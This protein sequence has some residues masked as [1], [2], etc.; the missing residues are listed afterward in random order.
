[1]TF[2]LFSERWLEEEP[3]APAAP[4][5]APLAV[6]D[7]DETLKNTL[8]V[9]GSLFVIVLILFCHLRRKYPRVYNVRNWVENLKTDLAQ[10]QYGYFNWIWKVFG[11]DDAEMMDQCGMDAICFVRVLE[12][13]FKLAAVGVVNS[14]WLMLIY[15]TAEDS[16]ETEH[17]F[18]ATVSL[19]TANVPSGSNRL[20]GTVVAAYIIY[21][22]CMYSILQEF[23]WFIKFRHSFLTKR[24]ARNY[25]VC[26]EYQNQN[27][28]SLP[29]QIFKDLTSSISSFS[30]VRF[31]STSKTFLWN[32]R[33]MPNSQSSLAVRPTEQSSRFI[34]LWNVPTFKRRCWNVKRLLPIWNMPLTCEK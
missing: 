14:V 13:G 15:K 18:A 23:E 22:F 28:I 24:L 26:Y 20:I 12:F 25:S 6:S 33:T 9:Y 32:T 29:K 16:P 34:W 19:S 4:T 27:L 21:G 10:E 31:R 2:F 8:R 11:L 17:I 7:D 30:L 3:S 5:E 1:M